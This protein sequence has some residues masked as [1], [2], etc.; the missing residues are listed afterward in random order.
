MPP[1]LKTA[2]LT[3]RPL[4]SGDAERILALCGDLAVSRWLSRVPHPYTPGDAERFIAE[5][6][7]G[8]VWAIEQ[9]SQPGLI[10][11][12]GLDGPS[13]RRMLGYW[14]GQPYWGRGL[15][16]E[17]ATAVIA[18]GFSTLRIIQLES[19]AFEGNASSLRIQE[20]LGFTITGQ[21]KLRCT[22]LDRE[23][24]HIDTLLTRAGWEARQHAYVPGGEHAE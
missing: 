2:R 6:R 18:Y 3:L 13:D 19:G 7:N 21:H 9:T 1:A 16:S 10:G 8:F 24:M 12:I 14:L 17:A 4:E 11:T 22:A 20:K 5:C 23:V 15:A